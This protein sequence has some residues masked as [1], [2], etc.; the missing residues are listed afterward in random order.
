MIV[1]LN[2][3]LYLSFVQPTDKHGGAIVSN[4]LL[5]AALARTLSIENHTLG[6]L[7]YSWLAEKY[8]IPSHL[9]LLH[10]INDFIA[11]PRPRDPPRETLWVL[12]IGFWDIWSLSALPRKLATRLIETQAQQIFSHI[13]LL[14]NEAHNNESAA[15]SD[16][17]A[18]MDLASLNTTKSLPRASFQ[19]LIPSPFDVSLT[20]GFESARSTPPAPHSKVEHM[21]NAA[22]L[23]RYWDKV[24]QD[25]VNEWVCLPDLEDVDE[26]KNDLSKIED[27]DL[28]LAKRSVTINGIPVPP[29]LREVITYD[30]LGYI[31]ELIV[32]RQLRNA[33]IIDHNGLGSLA[34]D[35]GYSEVWEP[36]IKRA[37][38]FD[39][40]ND[41]NT[42]DENEDGTEWTV[43][44][45]PDEHLFWTEFTVNRRAM[46]EIGKRAAEALKRHAET[47]AEWLEK[48][49]QPLSSLR[50]RP[51][52]APLR[53]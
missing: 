21:R 17:Y 9:D 42:T 26:D 28:L 33:D 24:I 37:D 27:A 45:A 23:T 8:P 19:V 47:D 11:S 44:K 34:A 10:Q 2:C 46:F 53:A 50:K 30:A 52:G 13:E 36:C 12:D 31:R 20:P 32:E 22:Y 35:E 51:D 38:T 49:G 18:G 14:Y 5:E 1:Q 40:S 29:A 43:C 39:D 15:F 41:K 6:G 25:L 7:D 16:Y 48:S 3:D 4:S